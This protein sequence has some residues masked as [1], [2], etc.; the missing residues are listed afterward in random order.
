MSKRKRRAKGVLVLHPTTLLNIPGLLV[1][2]LINLYS[3]VSWVKLGVFSSN[4]NPQPSSTNPLFL[5]CLGYTHS[6]DSHSVK[7]SHIHISATPNGAPTKLISLKIPQTTP[8]V[9]VPPKLDLTTLTVPLKE[10]VCYLT[11]LEGGTPED[12][13]EFV[14]R[15]YDADGNGYLDSSVSRDKTRPAYQIPINH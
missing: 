2:S 9:A 15:L 4:S 11:L 1:R 3:P 7:K 10:L 5:S 12:K 6:E 14:F 8:E 13:L